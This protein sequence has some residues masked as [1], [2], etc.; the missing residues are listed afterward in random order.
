MTFFDIK[1]AGFVIKV[2]NCKKTYETE[3]GY[4]SGGVDGILEEF[5]GEGRKRIGLSAGN[6]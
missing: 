1:V 2:A 3:R 6:G 4:V 5:G